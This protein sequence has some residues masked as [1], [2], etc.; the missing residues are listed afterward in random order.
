M[1]KFVSPNRT[2]RRPQKRFIVRTEAKNTPW[3]KLF[4]YF[5]WKQI[6]GAI[7]I[8]VGRYAFFFHNRSPIQRVVFTQETEAMLSYEPLF[9]TI[10]TDLIW[11]G[12]FKQ[13]RRD[14]DWWMQTVKAKF[15]LVTSIKP[16]SFENGT[17]TVGIVY[18]SPDFIM[19]TQDS[20][21]SIIYRN[22]IIPYNSWALLW[23]TGIQ[24][25]I[26]LPQEQVEQFSWG[27]FWATSSQD[28]VRTIKRINFLSGESMVTYYPWWEK[29]S[30]QAWKDTFII[31]LHSDTMSKTLEKWKHLLPYLPTAIPATVD[32]SN[33]DRIII[34]Q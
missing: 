11:K 25:Q 24:L 14:R 18:H 5:Y 26:S 7:L 15:P 22:S 9:E 33:P 3:W 8:I 13:K 31:G 4:L 20:V 2:V 1:R 27:V 30:I 34:K 6:I 16:I 28:I 12:Y 23:S 17:L 21:P 10:E 29:L 19:Y 32:M